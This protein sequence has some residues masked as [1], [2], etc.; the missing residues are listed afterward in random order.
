MLYTS[1]ARC[2][3]KIVAF[4]AQLFVHGSACFDEEH[5]EHQE[6]A[7]IRVEESSL[8]R[9]YSSLNCNEQLPCNCP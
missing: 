7:F 5:C 4:D 6:Q 1:I 3:E 2:S 8:E 9:L